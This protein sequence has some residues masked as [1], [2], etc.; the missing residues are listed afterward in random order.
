VPA[1]V[2]SSS[3]AR[4]DARTLLA[5]RPRMA[6]DAAKPSRNG[7]STSSAITGSIASRP[8]TTPATLIR[9]LRSTRIIPA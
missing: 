6:T 9:K 2:V 8:V 1:D 4:I 3:S 5:A 7:G